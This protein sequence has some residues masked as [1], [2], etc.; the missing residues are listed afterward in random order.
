MKAI[1]ILS[2]IKH[3]HE[4]GFRLNLI[5]HIDVFVQEHGTSYKIDNRKKE[6]YLQIDAY[7]KKMDF[8]SSPA[9]KTDVDDKTHVEKC[10]IIGSKKD[11][12]KFQAIIGYSSLT[13][14]A[15]QKQIMNSYLDEIDSLRSDISLFR[16]EIE[17]LKEELIKNY[18][19]ANPISNHSGNLN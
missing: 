7:E 6:L 16:H 14:D 12:R 5:N 8:T 1:E 19:G 17:E 11:I 10:T 9:I 2:F 3:R 18:S 4:C 13:E 15:S